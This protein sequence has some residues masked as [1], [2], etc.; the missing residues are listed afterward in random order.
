[1]KFFSNWANKE[2][3]AA[4]FK[5]VL[6]YLSYF[7]I[8]CLFTLLIGTAINMP[9][10]H[11]FTAMF[12]TTGTEIFARRAL[13]KLLPLISKKLNIQEKEED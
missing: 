13:W 6:F 3:V 5:V 12:V 8:M 9:I 11:F 1:M 2:K 4:F 7:A 10:E